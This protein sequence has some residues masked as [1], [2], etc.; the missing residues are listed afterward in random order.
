VAGAVTDG[1]A[2]KLATMAL[3]VL[4]YNFRTKEQ[5]HENETGSTNVQFGTPGIQFLWNRFSGFY[6]GWKPGK[7]EECPAHL[8]AD[9]LQL[10][11][12]WGIA[13][14]AAYVR[15]VEKA[16]GVE[17]DKIRWDELYDENHR[18]E[19]YTTPKDGQLP[20][21]DEWKTYSTADMAWE[22]AAAKHVHDFMNEAN[23]RAKI[24]EYHNRGWLDAEVTFGIRLV[25]GAGQPLALRVV[26][27]A[28][29]VSGNILGTRITDGDGEIPFF[30]K[31]YADYA[32]WIAEQPLSKS[33]EADGSQ[34][35]IADKILLEQVRTDG[36]I[37]VV[38]PQLAPATAVTKVRV[39]GSGD[40]ASGTAWQFQADATASA[41]KTISAVQFLLD[42]A[43]LTE[44]NKSP[45][46]ATLNTTAL[47]NGV[48]KLTA[49]ATDSGATI[50]TSNVLLVTVQNAPPDV[51]I[52]APMPGAF[53]GDVVFTAEAHA[54]AGMTM[55]KVHF[56]TQDLRT[57]G[58]DIL[59]QQGNPVFSTTMRAADFQNGDVRI[60]ARAEDTAGNITISAPVVMTVNAAPPTVAITTPATGDVVGTFALTAVAHPGLGMTLQNVQFKLGGTDYGAAQAGAPGLFTINVNAQQ[61]KNGSHRL[62]AVATDTSGNATT[63]AG[64]N[65]NVCNPPPTLTIRAPQAGLVDNY[66]V[67]DADIQAGAGMTLKSVQVTMNGDQIVRMPP[68]A[69]FLS[70]QIELEPGGEYEIVVKVTDSTGNVVVKTVQVEAKT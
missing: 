31:A 37:V 33:T 12:R 41:G 2:E 66:I 17:F 21:E 19:R 55:K 4:R 44:L 70:S 43:H 54:G 56:S 23:G 35:Q 47:K 29:P 22:E 3:P 38:K 65:I 63:S 34:L 28:A 10:T 61:L 1:D 64:V 48:H 14:S 62:T 39:S 69:P 52:T 15:T 51:E 16:L 13:H 42:G 30:D 59:A 53:V 26:Y 50:A 18:P 67:V 68:A 11:S 49:E 9:A 7:N 58:M 20:S 5:A 24:C 8:L 46:I 45:Y 32:F 6:V 25:D 60:V 36:E 27:C 40:P 57:V